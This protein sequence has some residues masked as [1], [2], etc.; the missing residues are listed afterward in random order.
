MVRVMAT[1]DTSVNGET[2]DN[3][4]EGLL[5]GLRMQELAAALGLK[6]R[7]LAIRLDIDPRH[8]NSLWHDKK[9][10][11]LPLVMKIARKSGRSIAWVCG[12]EAARPQI[13]TVNAHGLVTMANDT[14]IAP[15][16]MYFTEA[17]GDFV[18]PADSWVEERWLLVAP[19][20]GGERFYGWSF[21]SG[22][23]RMFERTDGELIGYQPERHEIIGVIVGTLTPPPSKPSARR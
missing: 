15:G 7:Q 9:A 18:D 21:T 5:I 20:K 14:K 1:T 23:M 3:G 12:E 8:F 17:S 22:A 6:Q 4:P 13:G 11:G 19:K 2:E 10:A 16:I